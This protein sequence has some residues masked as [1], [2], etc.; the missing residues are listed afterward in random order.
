M[1]DHHIQR[2]ILYRLALVPGLRFSELKPDELE[3]KLFTYHLKKVVS[4]GFVVK[5]IE[6]LYELTPEGRRLGAHVLDKTEARVDRA[7]SVL[8]L[9]VRNKA[10][11]WLLYKRKSHPLLGKVGFMHTTPNAAEEIAITAKTALRTKTGLNGSFK[12]LGSGF[13][14]IYE[15]SELESFTNFTLLVCE[16]ASGSLQTND[17]LADYFWSETLDDYR[18]NLLPNMRILIEKYTAGKLFFLE[19]QIKTKPKQPRVA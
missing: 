11:A 7:Y 9:V 13:F 18:S 14:R 12:V 8:F 17:E 5:S 19:R 16:D 6:G 3:N 10:G 15:K 1:L 2:A 4:A